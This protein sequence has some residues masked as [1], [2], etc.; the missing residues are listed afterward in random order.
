M[1]VINV[2]LLLIWMLSYP[3]FTNTAAQ[4]KARIIKQKI[5]VRATPDLKGKITGE[6]TRNELFTVVEQSGRWI[7]VKL[8]NGKTGWIHQS[9][10][11]IEIEPE[12]EIPGKIEITGRRVNVRSKPN[13]KGKKLGQVYKYDVIEA[14]DQTEK[15]VKIE[16]K[17]GKTGWIYKSLIKPLPPET[18]PTKIEK[19]TDEKKADL[20]PPP[21][22]EPMSERERRTEIETVD[23]SE[24][25]FRISQ[26]DAWIEF[27]GR[28]HMDFRSYDGAYSFYDVPLRNTF[29]LRRV[30]LI[31]SGEFNENIDFYFNSDLTKDRSSIQDAFINFRLTRNIAFR[32]GQFV[33][34]FS[35]GRATPTTLI[36]FIERSQVVDR[37]GPGLD[38]GVM[39]K[40]YFFRKRITTYIAA[41]NGN[42]ADRINKKDGLGYSIRVLFSPFRR[43]RKSP[44]RRLRFG[45]STSWNDNAENAKSFRGKSAGD[46]DF[47]DSIPVSGQERLAGMEMSWRYGSVSLKSEYI[48]GTQNREGLAADS[49]SLPPLEANGWYVSATWLLTGEER[50]L[51]V[52]PWRPMFSRGGGFGAIEL[53]VRLG[54]IIFQY[55]ADEDNTIRNSAQALTMGINWYLTS[56][57]RCQFNVVIN[58]F[59]ADKSLGIPV[60]KNVVTCLSRLQYDF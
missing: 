10:V 44:L 19:L 56:S 42:G 20:L 6:A 3:F 52:R 15:W 34:P 5:N 16:L 49:T 18:P 27:G 30:R 46:V 24:L 41:Y 12:F 37:L 50:K 54:G 38:I 32:A 60:D 29:I 17:K 4:E 7:K 13:L 31:L 47:F 33:I 2:W 57:M 58:R 21:A 11:K 28:L 43:T 23:K 35:L 26:E 8:E 55:E 39:L 40:T 36:D 14:L 25:H 9:L 22:E 48:A 51:K 53:A 45:G 1:K 59:G